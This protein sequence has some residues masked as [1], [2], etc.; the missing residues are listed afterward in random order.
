[1]ARFIWISDSVVY[2]VH[3]AQLA[4]HGGLAGIRDEGML[5]SALA[6]PKN[7]ASYEKP[8][9]AACAAAYGYGLSRNHPFLDGNKRTA[10]VA[11]ELFLNLND[12]ALEADDAEC[13]ITMLKVA[14]GSLSEKEFAIWIR[15]RLVALPT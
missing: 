9:A 15:E 2:A 13:L 7:L 12:F 1:M 14:E 3:E 6:R 4:E 5:A 10:F 8:D 11:V